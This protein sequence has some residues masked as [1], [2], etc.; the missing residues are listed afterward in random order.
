MKKIAI[1]LVMLCIFSNEVRAEEINWG[2]CTTYAPMPVLFIH[3]INANA[4]TWD[5]ATKELEKYFGYKW[6][7]YDGKYITP[8][9]HFY[10]VTYDEKNPNA[11][12]NKVVKHYLEAFDY[13]GEDAG[14]SFNHLDTY[15]DVLK[16][17]IE[18]DDKSPGILKSYYGD[19]Y[20]PT[21]DKLIIVAHS[22][23]GLIAR[24]YIQEK[25]GWKH[26]KR[27]ITIG[28]AHTGSWLAD[29]LI[30]RTREVPESEF[31]WIL[32]E[33]AI[34][35]LAKILKVE[36]IEDIEKGAIQDQ[37]TELYQS[38][39]SILG[40]AYNTFLWHLNNGSGLRNLQD[41]VE[42]VCIVGKI[43]KLFYKDSDAIVS[44]NSQRG[45][46]EILPVKYFEPISIIDIKDGLK[47]M[48]TNRSYGAE[49]F[50]DYHS[51]QIYH[52]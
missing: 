41:N 8:D 25:D 52:S 36:K 27:L 32:Q 39:I 19:N 15:S 47:G 50:K 33:M 23:G 49:F 5:T 10:P 40:H 18:G 38:P 7:R 29:K 6:M 35:G 44:G 21:T 22:Q 45:E 34:R 2:S 20:N 1:C 42:V 28:T 46:S 51:L 37:Q 9:P 12:Q 48:H 26:V 11:P 31:I 24:H 4:T 13:G 3:G 17:L 16:R 30:R 43:G 14:K